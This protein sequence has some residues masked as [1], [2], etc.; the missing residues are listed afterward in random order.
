MK[1]LI[2]KFS[3]PVGC[4]KFYE[5]FSGVAPNYILRVYVVDIDHSYKRQIDKADRKEASTIYYAVVNE[6][7]EIYEGMQTHAEKIDRILSRQ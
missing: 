4:I 7:T 3:N 2:G 6:L 1:M 5:D